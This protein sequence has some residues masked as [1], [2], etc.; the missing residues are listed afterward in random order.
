MRIV[1]KLGLP[2]SESAL[3]RPSRLIPTRRASSLRLPERATVPNAWAMYSGEDVAPMRRVAPSNDSIYVPQNSQ[4]AR[5]SE[6]A[7]L[8]Y[9][10]NLW[11]RL[12]NRNKVREPHVR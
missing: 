11:L 12:M 3:Y 9:T 4:W 10:D 2:P 7:Q 5:Y 6:M 8:G 1:L